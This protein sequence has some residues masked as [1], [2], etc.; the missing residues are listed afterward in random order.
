M[1]HSSKIIRG[2]WACAAACLLMTNARPAQ[3]ESVSCVFEYPNA[4]PY[5]RNYLYGFNR[6]P[7]VITLPDGSLLASRFTGALED[8]IHQLILGATSRDG[9][10][11]WGTTQS[12]LSRRVRISGRQ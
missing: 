8:D 2:V 12:W 6:A 4:V 7:N 10:A 1:S 3:I 5:D 9:D 11:R